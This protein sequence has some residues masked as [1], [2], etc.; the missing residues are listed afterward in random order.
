MYTE[1]EAIPNLYFY[2]LRIAQN[3]LE[4][5]GVIDTD[6]IFTFIAKIENKVFI[7]SLKDSG[8]NYHA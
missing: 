3:S 6:S 7:I 5:N 8:V 1:Q 2:L 4:L